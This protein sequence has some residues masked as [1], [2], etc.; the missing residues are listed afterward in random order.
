[1]KTNAKEWQSAESSSRSVGRI[2]RHTFQLEFYSGGVD[3]MPVSG[4]L[5]KYRVR[6][7]KW[8][9]L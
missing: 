7:R 9:P 4:F 2:A 1:V 5:R 6:D 8:P 3:K